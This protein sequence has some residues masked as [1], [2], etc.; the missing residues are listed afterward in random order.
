M[1]SSGLEADRF[2]AV[3]LRTLI[4]VNL[5]MIGWLEGGCP[6]T[7]DFPP[8]SASVLL[9]PNIGVASLKIPET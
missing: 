9:I 3:E 2:V 1:L 5:F 4:H 8:V 7:L 6:D